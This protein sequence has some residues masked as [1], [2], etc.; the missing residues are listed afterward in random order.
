MD[1]EI[2]KIQETFATFTFKFLSQ[3][4]NFCSTDIQYTFFCLHSK[5]RET[6]IP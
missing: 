5:V 1:T 4:L 2:P 6:E 3:F